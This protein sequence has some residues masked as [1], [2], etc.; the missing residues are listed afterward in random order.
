MDTSSATDSNDGFV[1]VNIFE[2]GTATEIA[3]GNIFSSAGIIEAISVIDTSDQVSLLVADNIESVF[4]IDIQSNT[5]IGVASISE[6]LTAIEE[7]ST[8][9]PVLA[10][11]EEIIEAMDFVTTMLYLSCSI[12]EEAS[13][14]GAGGG[15]LCWNGNEWVET[16]TI[17][18]T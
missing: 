13:I 6:G 5:F 18:Y 7:Y 15:P 11:I 8:N 10:S 17:I 12:S 2:D 16:T 1:I 14:G 4:V 3:N 9:M